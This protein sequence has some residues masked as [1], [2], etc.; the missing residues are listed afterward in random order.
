MKFERFLHGGD[1]NPE[2]WIENG[3]YKSV[4]E[5]DI[6]QLKESGINFVTAG[7][8]SWAYYNPSEDEYNF[9]YMDYLV[10]RYTEE[11]FDIIMSTPS[12]GFPNWLKLK[13]PSINRTGSDGVRRTLGDRHNHCYNSPDSIREIENINEILAERYKDSNIVLWH[14]ENEM[15]GECYCEH[16]VRE[17]R[18]W[19][20]ECYGSIENLNKQWNMNFWSHTYNSFE[21]VNPP[22]DF[23]DG[24]NP[25]M[26]LAWTRFNTHSAKQM[27]NRE[28]NAIQRHVPDAKHTTNLCYGLGHN[29]NYHSFAEVMDIVSWDSYHEWHRYNDHETAFYGILNFD[30]MRGLKQR[31]F[32]L[33]ES[34]PNTANWR[35]ASKNKREKMHELTSMLAIAGGSQSVG[36]FQMKRSRN[37]AEMFHSAVIDDFVH[38]NRFTQE[39]KELGDNLIGIEEILD[40]E[41]NNDIAIIFDYEIRDIIN[42]NVGPRK[43]GGMEYCEYFEEIH[44][45][46]TSNN[47]AVDVVNMQA[48]LA[49]YKAV[50]IPMHFMLS[51]E[52]ID[53]LVDLANSGI[54]QYVTAFTGLTDEENNLQVGGLNPKF[55]DLLGHNILEYEAIY[56]DDFA[57]INVLGNEVKSKIFHE[58]IEVIE[59][60]EVIATYD[61]DLYNNS[62]VVTKKDNVTYV[63]A[64]IPGIDIARIVSSDLGLDLVKTDYIKMV[65][66][67][68]DFDYEFY[69][70]F[71]KQS[72]KVSANGTNLL[73]GEVVSNVTLEKYEYVI[74]KKER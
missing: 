25:C 39:L 60:T 24:S 14:I 10:K 32:F 52:Q 5:K 68:D 15:Q 9:D 40:T 35:Y 13:Y 30:L 7:V 44:K 17:F 11:G 27:Y 19:L 34:T 72:V 1:Y 58:Y 48:D 49:R 43:I 29:F 12:G 55:R 64:I 20:E 67:N 51:E 21:E 36:Y 59:G 8:F 31:N 4:I 45:A 62:P 47:V 18:V 65:R 66:S 70:N 69:F 53:K 46:F 61:F 37:H 74:I 57:T 50:V 42:Y 3:D 41:V 54:K 2:Q 71:N 26:R 73:T 23:G 33:M 22:Y 28:I 16:C 6:K 56:D 38:K 63:G